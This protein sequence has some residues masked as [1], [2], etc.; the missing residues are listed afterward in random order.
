MRAEDSPFAEPLCNPPA[1][2]Q[3]LLLIVVGVV[4]VVVVDGDVVE[5]WT[6]VDEP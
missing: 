1:L 2:A 4:G 5:G 3:P 6:V